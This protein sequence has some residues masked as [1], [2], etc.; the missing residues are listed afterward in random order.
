MCCRRGP[1]PF[2]GI[3]ATGMA[4]VWNESSFYVMRVLLGAAES[5]FIPGAIYYI[6][7][8]FPAA[9]RGR[10]M[11]LFLLA[12]PLSSVVGFPLSAARGP[13]PEAGGRLYRRRLPAVARR[14]CVRQG[15]QSRTRQ[16]RRGLN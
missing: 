2:R 8:W 4:F 7:L 9:Y 15:R 6:S 16:D 5:A 10:I 11:V 13:P 12:N 14:P 1:S 3:V